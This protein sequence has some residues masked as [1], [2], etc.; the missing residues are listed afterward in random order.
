MALDEAKLE[1]AWAV[2]K[3]FVDRGELE[4]SCLG[5][6][7]SNGVTSQ[8]FGT[9]G[10]PGTS[11]PITGQYQFLLASVSKP[12]TG[13]AI[14]RLVEQGKLVPSQPVQSLIPEFAAPGKPD[15]TAWHLM[16]HTSGL[17]DIFWEGAGQ[18]DFTREAAL[19][20]TYRAVPQFWPG[21][22][23]Q[24]NTLTF[25][26]LG[27]LVERLDGRSLDAFLQGEFFDGLGISGIV[28]DPALL[29]RRTVMPHNLSPDPRISPEQAVRIFGAAQLPG[30]GFWADMDSLLGLA[31]ALLLDARDGQARTL[32]PATLRLMT[33]LH[34]EG[35]PRYEMN[36]TTSGR[37]GLT[38]HKPTTLRERTLPGSP[39][40]FTHS[41]ATGT[42][43]WVDPEADL[44]VTFLTN[45]WGVG[46]DYW[47]KCLQAVYAAWRP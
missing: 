40:V 33:E 6:G 19:D 23:W 15:I 9:A 45:H 25:N 32:A 21:T 18:A 38:W 17:V 42:V 26:L 13:L 27:Q 7:T 5:I 14:M 34:T 44:A 22:K 1:R 30:A 43:L 37:Y 47:A 20:R 3:G 31:Q 29:G 41:G 39:G 46:D 28:L 10:G 8:L 16:T 36:V 12:I 2:A 4:T 11:E 24:Y 35:I